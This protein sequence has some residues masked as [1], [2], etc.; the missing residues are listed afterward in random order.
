MR[1]ANIIITLLALVII[2]VIVIYFTGIPSLFNFYPTQ[3]NSKNINLGLQPLPEAGLIRPIAFEEAVNQLSTFLLENKG[4]SSNYSIYYIRGTNLE[5]DGRALKWMFGITYENQS[6]M[7]YYDQAGWQSILWQGGLPEK[8]IVIGS[9]LS[10]SEIIQKNIGIIF[11]SN[12]SQNNRIERLEL[13]NGIYT[14]T[15]YR[16]DM[17][18]IFSFDAVSGVLIP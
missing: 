11:G 7:M 8:E 16:Q 12:P 2:L 3:Q 13:N 5:N 18:Q 10:P 15:V 17:K 9:I 6:A 4:I 14:L 1:K